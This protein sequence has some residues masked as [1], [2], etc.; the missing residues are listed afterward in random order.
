MFLVFFTEIPVPSITYIPVNRRKNHDELKD[1][2]NI[3]I[4]S[5]SIAS[6]MIDIYCGIEAR[7]DRKSNRGANGGRCHLYLSFLRTL[8][9]F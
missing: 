2:L 6:Y 9:S 3:M 1:T 5:S 7:A 4:I 8:A